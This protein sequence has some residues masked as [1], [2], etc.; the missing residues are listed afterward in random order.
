MKTKTKIRYQVDRFNRLV[1]A[2]AKRRS[3]VSQF[4]TVLDGRFALDSKNNLI[5]SYTDPQSPSGTKKIRL[6]GTWSLDQRDALTFTLEGTEN[7]VS[8]NKLALKGELIDADH[9][10]L[11]ISLTTKDAARRE[12]VYV[13]TFKG[14]W[15][16]DQY[17]R[18]SFRLTRSRGRTDIL[19]LKGIWEINRNHELCYISRQSARSKEYALVFKGHWDIPGAYRLSYL[20]EAD[21]ASGFEFHTR[22]ALFDAEQKAFIYTVFIGVK[23]VSRIVTVNGTWKV[24]RDLGLLFEIRYARARIGSI[25]FGATCRLLDHYTVTA[26]LKTKNTDD[27]GI[28]VRLKRTLFKDAGEVFC[29]ASAAKDEWEIAAGVGL[30]W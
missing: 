1:Y 23:P 12:T 8:G 9:G 5:Y 24:A 14:I 19:T 13:L 30:R 16:A 11:S 2:H 26:R 15:C 25:I 29:N 7:Q 18:L 17:N 3:D 27:L 10:S 22:L 6:K 20:L 4:K 21:T 28:D